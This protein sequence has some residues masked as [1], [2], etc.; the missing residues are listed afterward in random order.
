MIAIGLPLCGECDEP[1][2]AQSSSQPPRS[3]N[4][5]NGANGA[6]GSL[7]S[8]TN[9]LVETGL[10]ALPDG[11]VAFVRSAAWRGRDRSAGDAPRAAVTSN[12]LRRTAEPALPG[13]RCDHSR[14]VRGQPEAGS[15]CLRGQ[16][17]DRGATRVTRTG[18]CLNVASCRGTP[19]SLGHS[20]SSPGGPGESHPRAPTERNVTVSRHS[21]LLI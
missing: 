5:A 2:G 12:R 6:N 17:L 14:T 1:E 8:R 11:H 18:R 19:S 7:R 20:P 9:R 3:P 16:R 15:R 4:G 21:A 13:S 10:T